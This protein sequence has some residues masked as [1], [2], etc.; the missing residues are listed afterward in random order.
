MEEWHIT[1]LGADFVGKTNLCRRF[2]GQAFHSE[3]SDP[4]IEDIYRQQKI[5]D[6]KPCL[7]DATRSLN[8]WT[9]GGPELYIRR[10]K[11]FLLVYSV[12]SRATFDGLDIF[13]QAIRRIKED[14]SV[15]LILLGNKCDD[16][17]GREV[18][19][20]E[21]AALARKHGCPFLEVSAKTNINVERAFA[22]LVRLLRPD[23]IEVAPLKKPKRLKKCI[24]F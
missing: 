14:D 7:V 8:D 24:I 22:D 6:S 19:M 4:T 20:E 10:G 11:A 12:S 23:V 17:L 3:L 15:P 18:A 2:C 21:G 9:L 5:V 16:A 1:L 13:W